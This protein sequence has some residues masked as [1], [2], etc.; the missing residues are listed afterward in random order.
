MNVGNTGYIPYDGIKVNDI[1]SIVWQYSN[2]SNGLV[3][4]NTLARPGNIP[5]VLPANTSLSLM[6]DGKGWSISLEP[7]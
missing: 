2:S 7:F 4:T 5:S 6:Y 1:V 3:M